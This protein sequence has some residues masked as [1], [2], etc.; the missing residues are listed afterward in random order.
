MHHQVADARDVRFVAVLLEEEPLK[1]L[2]ALEAIGRQQRCALR[3]V[4]ND[5]I[6]LEQQF[7]AFQFDSWNS[8]VRKF[9]EELGRASLTFRDVEFDAL[10]RNPKLRQQQA[11]LVAVARRKIV[12]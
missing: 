2:R 1:N 12:V 10:E 4:Q 6:R 3:K 11:N 5:R 7:A 9:A 8:A